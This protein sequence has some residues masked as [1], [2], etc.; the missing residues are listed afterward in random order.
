MRMW[1]FYISY[2]REQKDLWQKVIN[3]KRVTFFGIFPPHEWYR[4]GIGDSFLRPTRFSHFFLK[5]V[6][7]NLESKLISKFFPLVEGLKNKLKLT[8]KWGYEALPS[9]PAPQAVATK[10]E[11]LKALRMVSSVIHSLKAEINFWGAF[12]SKDWG[13]GEYSADGS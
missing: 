3:W 5:S 13:P 7:Q 4:N 8:H 2:G 10:G 9:L 12:S 6:I 11:S 1:F